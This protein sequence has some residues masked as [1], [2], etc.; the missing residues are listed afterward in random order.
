MANIEP[1]EASAQAC[2]GNSNASDA[3]GKQR[4]CPTL[5]NA[6]ALCES[7]SNNT[8]PR[9]MPKLGL[10]RPTGQARV[11]I[12]GKAYY[13][14]RWGTA[15]AHAKYADLLRRHVENN[16]EPVEQAPNVEQAGYLVRDLARDYLA[17][18]DATGRHWKNGAPTSQRHF[19]EF[20]L[21]S[22]GEYLGSVPVRRLRESLLVQWR[23]RLEAKRELT[24]NG[25]NRKVR[26]L[27]AVLRWGRA[28]GHVSREVWADCAAIES[29]RR[30]QCG[31]RPEHGR[32]R[33]APSFEEI[34]RVVTACTSRQ[35]AAMLRLQAI[36]A[37]RPGEVAAMRWQDI[38]QRP[39]EAGEGV[40]CWTYTVEAPKTAH[41]G[42]TV[43]YYLPP[44]AIA[45]LREFPGTPRAYVFSPDA[46]MAERR[47]AL[48]DARQ[49]PVTDYTRQLDEARARTFASRWGTHAYRHAVERACVE[50][51][52]ER[53]TPHE[54]RHA[55]LTW[56][57]NSLGVTAAMAI[58]NHASA[59]VT[60]RYVHRDERHALAAIAA[61]QR[62]A[63]GG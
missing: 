42:K 62:R 63:A 8:K 7:V 20:V 47:K 27:L 39:V 29:L 5:P 56:I 24:R 43:R 21:R 53:F 35:V 55:A 18:I 46:S 15:E 57:A 23:D 3:N 2:A 34:E 59:Q 61:V 12:R 19:V 49:T 51:G 41:H 50:A 40:I 58:A 31:N 37:M 38:D 4:Q 45:I 44:A 54:A 14:G 10:H 11:I 48:R 9:R 22:F 32:P 13:C 6:A 60:A 33:R 26:S 17:W 28:R 52:V 16:G 36:T 25:I 30:G 1:K